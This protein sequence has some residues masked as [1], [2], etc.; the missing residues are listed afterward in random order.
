MVRFDA[1]LFVCALVCW[2]VCCLACVLACLFWR[3]E[4]KYWKD[5]WWGGEGGSTE[6]GWCQHTHTR[7]HAVVGRRR[8]CFVRSFVGLVVR[9]FVWWMVGWSVGPCHS[10]S[11][12]RGVECKP[13]EQ[14]RQSRQPTVRSK[15]T[16]RATNHT[17]HCLMCVCVCVAFGLRLT[18]VDMATCRVGSDGAVDFGWERGSVVRVDR[19]GCIEH[20]VAG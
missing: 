12:C 4:L 16:N 8:C 14:H 7:T 10:V 3:W 5:G 20:W 1:C 9:S 19:I 17:Q 11:C 15:R 18:S 2:F 13:R 6:R